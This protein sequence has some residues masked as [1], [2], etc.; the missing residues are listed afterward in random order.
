MFD[1]RCS[2]REHRIGAGRPAAENHEECD[3]DKPGDGDQNEEHVSRGIRGGPS[4]PRADP[5]PLSLS[6]GAC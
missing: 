4:L 5:A 1:R 3:D 6:D 2:R